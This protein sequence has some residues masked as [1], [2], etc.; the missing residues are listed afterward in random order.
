MFRD[1]LIVNGKNNIIL[2]LFYY[3][4]FLIN[5]HKKFSKYLKI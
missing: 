1:I 5:V 3:F 2:L 4:I